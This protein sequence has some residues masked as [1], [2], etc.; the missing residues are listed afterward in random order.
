MAK[1]EVIF[2]PECGSTNV[3]GSE[4]QFY[5]CGSCGFTQEDFPSA[6]ED[7]VVLFQTDLKEANKQVSKAEESVRQLIIAVILVFTLVIFLL[8]YLAYSS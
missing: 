3:S 5:R 1:A 8:G 4:S 6:P 2:C 7:E